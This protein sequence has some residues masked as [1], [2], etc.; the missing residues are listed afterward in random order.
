MR[1]PTRVAPIDEHAI[2]LDL[3]ARLDIAEARAT[4]A[5]D[6]LHGLLL[7]FARL[8]RDFSTPQQQAAH[9]EAL[10]VLAEAGRGVLAD[11]GRNVP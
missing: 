10:A 3:L 1:M 2:D 9:R 11:A 6:A 4:C 7:A 8:A 5:L